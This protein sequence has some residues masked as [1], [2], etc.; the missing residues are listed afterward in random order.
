MKTDSSVQTANMWSSKGRDIVGAKWLMGIKRYKPLVKKKN[1]KDV[2]NS[3]RNMV[4]NIVIPLC[5]DRWLLDL[6]W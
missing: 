2:I 5:V 6:S 3:I 1:H 4:N